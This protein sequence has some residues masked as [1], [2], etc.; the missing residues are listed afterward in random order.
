MDL[1][2]FL[3]YKSRIWTHLG[4][5]IRIGFLSRESTQLCLETHLK[6]FWLFT[7]CVGSASEDSHSH[8]EELSEAGYGQA[9]DVEVTGGVQIEARN[10]YV[11]ES[12]VERFIFR[13]YFCCSEVVYCMGKD[14]DDVYTCCQNSGHHSLP[15]HRG[16]SFTSDSSCQ[17]QPA[18]CRE[19]N[20]NI[21][22]EHE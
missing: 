10:S 2:W 7:R 19:H 21:G 17:D 18:S 4:Y 16:F 22:N 14:G 11:V 1:S 8:P 9:V 12:F 15:F 5:T 6:I 3:T 13:I 20:Q